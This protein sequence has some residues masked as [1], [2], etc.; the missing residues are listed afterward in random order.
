MSDSTDDD[1]SNSP[2]KHGYQDDALWNAIESTGALIIPDPVGEAKEGRPIGHS[3]HN[4]FVKCKKTKK[5]FL[6]T[7]RQESKVNLKVTSKA[8]GVKELRL[9]SADLVLEKL[10]S[11]KG[12][13]TCLSL[14][15]DI[16]Q[17]VQ[18]VV[19][20]SL[21]KQQPEWCLCAGCHDPLNHKQHNVTTLTQAQLSSILALH[22][23]QKVEI[24]IEE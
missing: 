4:L 10:H 7:A 16:D 12:C 3:T 20:K 13:I 2:K 15:Y 8:L 5:L 11:Q 23:A 17:S 24:D 14:F 22:W 1:N 19:E 9:A 6:I 21:L 18:W